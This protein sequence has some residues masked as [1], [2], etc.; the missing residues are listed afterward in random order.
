MADMRIGI[1]TQMD[2]NDNAKKNKSIYLWH[3]LEKL[4]IC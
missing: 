1:I 4:Q 2:S 3:V